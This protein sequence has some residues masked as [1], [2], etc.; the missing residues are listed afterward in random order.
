MLQSKENQENSN[1]TKYRNTIKRYT[2][3]ASP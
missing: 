3:T 2:Y 1:N